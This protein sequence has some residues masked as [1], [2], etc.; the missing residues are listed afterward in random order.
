LTVDTSADP[1]TI[2]VEEEYQLV[3]PESG[4]LRSRARAV[5]SADWTGEIHP[6]MNQNTIEVQ[7]RPCGSI[8]EV[9]AELARLRFQAAVA[10]ETRGL[11]VMAAGTHPFSDWAAQEFTPGEAYDRIRLDYGRLAASQNIFGMH[12]HVAV[13]SDMDRARILNVVREYTHLLLALSASSPLF[14]GDETGYASYRS[15]LW[16]RWPRSGAPPH[17][18]SAR[19]LKQLV[20]ALIETGSID[21]PGRLYWDVRPHHVYPTIEF[22]AADVTPRLQD[23]ITVAA[24]ARLIVVGAAEGELS[25]APAPESLLRTFLIENGWRAARYG[26][27]AGFVDLSTGAPK[28]VPAA[29]AIAMLIERLEPVARSLGDDNALNG[30]ADLLARGGASER[31]RQR[32]SESGDRA[33]LVE[34]L[35]DETVL[36]LGLDRRSTQRGD[37]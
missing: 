8:K 37:V 34:W 4:E 9:G 26:M 19:E 2:G 27:A 30:V 23:A 6:E 1:Y 24:L 21:G 12:V 29:D 16:R 13:P 20:S 7:T 25:E 14:L 15:I 28:V 33:E 36:G 32:W 3:D 10:A 35:A 11:R 18:E 31:I 5:I 22:R 17:F